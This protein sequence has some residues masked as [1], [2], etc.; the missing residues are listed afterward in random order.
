MAVP[1]EAQGKTSRVEVKAEDAQQN[2]GRRNVDVKLP[3]AAELR[4]GDG[5]DGK[6]RVSVS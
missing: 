6:F 3:T 2:R 4:E 5:K 1:K